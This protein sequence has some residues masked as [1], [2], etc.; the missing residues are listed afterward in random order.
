MP[1]REDLKDWVANAQYISNLDLTKDYWQVPMAKSSTPNKIF[2]YKFR[3]YQKN[4]S[5]LDLRLRLASKGSWM[6]CWLTTPR[7]QQLATWLMWSYLGSLR[8]LTASGRPWLTAKLAKCHLGMR[9]VEYLRHMVMV[10][11]CSSGLSRASR[12]ADP[13]PHNTTT[14]K[15]VTFYQSLCSTL[16]W[17]I[18][19]III[20]LLYRYRIMSGII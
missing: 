16:A 7:I 13:P 19:I 17:L 15:S 8:F 14:K 4:V 5:L 1:R 18:I 11:K 2:K 10:G 9:E 20:S 12:I 6:G 3:K